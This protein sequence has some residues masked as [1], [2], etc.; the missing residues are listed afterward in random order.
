MKKIIINYTIEK[1]QSNIMDYPVNYHYNHSPRSVEK[2]TNDSQTVKEFTGKRE[3][4]NDKQAE[5]FLERLAEFK[6]KLALR[7]ANLNYTK[8]S[9]LFKLE[10][11]YGYKL[12]YKNYEYKYK[13]EQAIKANVYKLKLNIQTINL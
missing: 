2:V 11:Q 4:T 10:K 3:F 13:A 9:D 5:K 8:K 7:C 6:L 12:P 1:K